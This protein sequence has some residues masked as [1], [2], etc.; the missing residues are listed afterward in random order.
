M[1]KLVLTLLS[2]VG[3]ATA[4]LCL[5]SA[6][7]AGGGGNCVTYCSPPDPCGQVCCYRTCCGNSCIDLLCTPPCGG[8]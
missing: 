8:S 7:A 3:F 5:P 2:L 1:R 6:Q 4:L